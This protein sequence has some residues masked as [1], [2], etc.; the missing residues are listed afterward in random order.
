MYLL[1]MFLIL[2]ASRPLKDALDVLYAGLYLLHVVLAL[3]CL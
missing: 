2:V 3:A 1:N